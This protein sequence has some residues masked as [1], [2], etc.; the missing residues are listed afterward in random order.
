L[1]QFILNFRIFHPQIRFVVNGRG[2]PGA[3]R[4]K[5]GHCGAGCKS[6]DAAQTFLELYL[7]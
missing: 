4:G 1:I 5:P 3:L 2:K 7:G 6:F